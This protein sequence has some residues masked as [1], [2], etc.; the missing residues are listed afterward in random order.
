MRG[1]H[2]PDRTHQMRRD[3]HPGVALG[4]RRANAPKPLALQRGE[5]AMD[6]SWRG[7]RGGATEVA[8]FKQNDPEPAPRGVACNANAVQTAADD[9]KVVVRH[10]G[11]IAF[12]S[13]GGS[14]PRQ[15]NAS[16]KEAGLGSDL[17]RA[18]A[19]F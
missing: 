2:E 6:Q 15:E 17:R 14:G 4:Q 16:N 13:E 1:D 19:L 12:S 7:A 18:V 3:P 8:L 9:R 10:P 11:T 5:I